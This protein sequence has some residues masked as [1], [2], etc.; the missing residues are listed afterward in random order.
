MGEYL[1]WYKN[2]QDIRDKDYPN[3]K[4]IGSSV[5]DFEFHYTIRTLFNFFNIKYDA[6]SSLSHE[7]ATT[8]IRIMLIKRLIFF[9]IS[10]FNYN[11]NQR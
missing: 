10:V 11:S 2:I 7:M 3:I 5:I 8:T 6:F 1:K 4:L 9:M